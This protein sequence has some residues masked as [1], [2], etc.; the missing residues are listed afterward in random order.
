VEGLGLGE[1]DGRV[2]PGEGLGLRLGESDPGQS[3]PNNVHLNM[4]KHT[5][6]TTRTTKQAT[7]V[8]NIL[9][10]FTKL[11]LIIDNKLT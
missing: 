9:L 1:V 11:I 6:T 4:Y 3:V 10:S 2:E 8:N 7:P 5:H